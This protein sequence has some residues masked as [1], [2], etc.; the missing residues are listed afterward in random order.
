[1]A[2]VVGA[3]EE[4]VRAA[5][6]DRTRSDFTRRRRAIARRIRAWAAETGRLVRWGV[7][8][9]PPQATVV[10]ISDSSNVRALLEALPR[11]TRPRE[12]RVFRSR[13]G[14]EGVR[15]VRALRR[16]GLTA[17]VVDDGDLVGSL[18]DADLVLLGAD[19][20]EP[21]GSLVHKWGTR[22]L[23]EAAHGAHV[24]VVVV[25]GQSKRAPRRLRW[26]DGG[27]YDRTPARLIREVWT[28]A[29]RLTPAELR[30]AP[31]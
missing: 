8:V 12:V 1:M 30:R 9:F 22:P 7:V 11:A 26:A 29:G 6:L 28:D 27:R 19:A 31:R 15:A 17:H 23:A 13:P 24:P 3:G 25:A 21:D 4:L 20:L 18:H 10:S 16:A 5:R 14:G 2:P